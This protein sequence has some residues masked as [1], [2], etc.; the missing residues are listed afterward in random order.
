MVKHLLAQS[1]LPLQVSSERGSHSDALFGPMPCYVRQAI[2]GKGVEVATPALTTS[3]GALELMA[4]D[5]HLQRYEIQYNL[6]A[7]R[8]CCQLVIDSKGCNGTFQSP[9]LSGWL[10]DSADAVELTSP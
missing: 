2:T 10:C 6:V 5:L 1:A 8:M 3:E 4:A 7:Q 9:L